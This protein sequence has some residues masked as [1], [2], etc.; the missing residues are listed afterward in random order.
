MQ[1]KV[2]LSL[3]WYNARRSVLAGSFWR[4]IHFLR[5]KVF[6]QVLMWKKG[7]RPLRKLFLKLLIILRI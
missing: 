4:I 5:R 7:K 3:T 1:S 2:I 6:V